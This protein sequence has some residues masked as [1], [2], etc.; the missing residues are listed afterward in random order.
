LEIEY[1]DD[2]CVTI[3]DVFPKTDFTIWGKAGGEFSTDFQLSEE[4][5]SPKSED[6]VAAQILELLPN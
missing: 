4:L 1:G 2:P 5:K 3:F 6:E